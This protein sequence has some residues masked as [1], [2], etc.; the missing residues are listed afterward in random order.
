MVIAELPEPLAAPAAVTPP[1]L[2]RRLVRSPVGMIVLTWLAVVAFVALLGRWLAPHDPTST[3]PREALRGPFQSPYWL[4]TDDAGR[5]VLSRLIVA[6]QNSMLAVVLAV[7][8]AL[9]VGAVVGLIAGYYTGWFEQ[10]SSWVIN[11]VMA[12]PGIIILLAARAVVGPSIFVAMSIFGLLLAPAFYRLVSTT[13][14]AVANE[15]YIDAARVSGISDTRI[16]RRHVLGVVRGPIIIQTA[17]VSAVAI[18]VMSGLALIGFGDPNSP[19]WGTL[20]SSGFARIYRQRWLVVWPAVVIA[21]TSL[22]FTMLGNLL[23]DELEQG[24]GSSG[25]RRRRSASPSAT[26]LSLVPSAAIEHPSPAA[27]EPLLSTRSLVVGYPSPTAEEWRHVVA[28]VDLDVGRGEV[29]GL[30]GESGSGKTQFAFAVMGLL[31]VGGQILDGSIVFDGQELVG[32][33]DAA[34]RLRGRRIS[35]VPQ[36]P[37]S[38][39]DPAFTVGSQLVEPMRACLGMDK[40]AARQRALDLLDRVGIAE[41][42]RVFGSYPHQLSGGMAQRVLIAGAVASEPDLLIA[43]E[44]TTALDVTVQA[45]ILNLLRQLQQDTGMALLLVTHN[46]GVVADLAERVSVMQEGRI[47]ETGPVRDIFHRARHPYTRSLLAAI[48]DNRPARSAYEPKH[49]VPV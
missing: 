35:Y 4:G 18:A 23:R 39:L 32:D 25:G 15:P 26:E 22:S 14:R 20:L 12:M 31:S 10:T 49:E 34:A 43:D 13:V 11:L 8:I 1:R 33:P 9:A 21:C 40:Q 27:V 45:E 28:G 42:G 47:V 2:L 7:S 37:M 17:I 36:E 41:P 6:T 46:F 5:D 19:T 3:N 44:P 30:V 24:T 16:I 29:H 38:N 48:L